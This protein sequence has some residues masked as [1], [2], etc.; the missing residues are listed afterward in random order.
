[1][2]YMMK[3]E[4]QL[5]QLKSVTMA[6]KNQTGKKKACMGCCAWLYI[7]LLSSLCFY[8]S[9][10]QARITVKLQCAWHSTGVHIG[11]SECVPHTI[12]SRH[13]HHMCVKTEVCVAHVL[14][15][16]IEGQT[17]LSRYTHHLFYS[18][19]IDGKWL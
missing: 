17:N 9:P 1:M 4:S 18:V 10:F 15:V 3:I 7:Y 16:F 2:F 11:T 12:L 13:A 5:M 14:L 8:S 6:L 19:G